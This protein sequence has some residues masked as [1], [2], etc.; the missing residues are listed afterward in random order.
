MVSGLMPISIVILFKFIDIHHHNHDPVTN[1]WSEP[2]AK[3]QTVFCLCKGIGTRQMVQFQIFLFQNLV[4]FFQLYPFVSELFH[5]LL[6]FRRKFLHAIH[7]VNQFQYIG[8]V[9]HFHI[10]AFHVITLISHRSYAPV[11]VMILQCLPGSTVT[12]GGIPPQQMITLV[13]RCI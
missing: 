7:F 6:I 11:H 5:A 3:P 13:R 12:A 4:L 1:K 2:I 10:A 9:I 8:L